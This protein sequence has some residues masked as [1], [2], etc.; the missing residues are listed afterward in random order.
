MPLGAD[1]D[2]VCR[3]LLRALAGSLK[4]IDRAR[5]TRTRRQAHR[6]PEHLRV[7]LVPID[8]QFGIGLGP[9]ADE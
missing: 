3:H 5:Q 6:R 7:T 4:R 8:L 1:E 9:E 2:L